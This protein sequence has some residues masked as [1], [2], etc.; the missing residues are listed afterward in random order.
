MAATR[1]SGEGAVIG[2][3]ALPSTIMAVVSDV[4]GTLV[5]SD[6][7][8]AP[9]TVEAVRKLHDASVKFSIVSSRPPRGLKTVINHLNITTPVAGFNGGV[10][11]SP[12]LS[13]IASRVIAPDVARRAVDSI[14]A[15][16]ANVWVF[17]DNEWFVRDHNGPRVALEQRTVGFDPI[18]LD[19]FAAVIGNAAKI[20][21]VSDDFSLLTK[22][23]DRVRGSLAGGANVARSQ[24]YYLDFTHPLANKGNALLELAG[25]LAVSPGNTAVIGDGEND[26]VMFAQAGLSIAMGNAAAEVRQAADFVT[27]RDDDDGVA[28]AIDWFVL[29]RQ[30]TAIDSGR[31]PREVA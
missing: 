4:D 23:Q 6:K 13:V 25:L 5:R 1:C 27:R 29:G 11:V 8:L 10:I 30:R 18:V 7:S 31:H 24:P 2:R 26:V 3:V 21:A 9:R 22:L 20:V 19:D 28:A 12:K 14:E 17:S 15:S 16:G